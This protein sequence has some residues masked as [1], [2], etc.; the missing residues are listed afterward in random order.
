MFNKTRLSMLSLTVIAVLVFSAI[1]PK[2]VYA[3][4]DTPTN[5]STEIAGTSGSDT[6]GCDS[7]EA[8]PDSGGSETDSKGCTST[9]APTDTT[10]AGDSSGGET[11]SSECVSVEGATDTTST[12]TTN[13]DGA[14]TACTSEGAVTESTGDGSVSE[15]ENTA[16]Q[17]DQ[18]SAPVLTETAPPSDSNLLSEVPDNTSVTVL[19][20]DGQPEPLATQAAADAI[21]TT[22]DPIWCPQGQPPIPGANGCTAS[23]NSF[24]ALLTFL[25]GNAAYQGAGTIY[26]QQGAYHGGEA[27]ID[28]NSSSY[29]LSNI[30]NSDLTVQGGWD[31]TN[32]TLPPTSSSTLNISMIIGTSA[33]PWGG[34]L[35][36][37][38]LSFDKP[39]QT[40]LT[41]YSQNDITLENVNV[42]SSINGSGAE[43]NA[44]DDVTIINS[45]FIRNKNAGANITAGGNVAV[46]DSEFSNTATTRRQITGL[47]IDTKTKHTIPGKGNV[48]LFNVIANG[49]L[50]AGVNIDA[51]GRVSISNGIFSGTK[52]MTTSGGTTTFSGYGLQ[53]VTSDAIDLDN[54][55][56]NDN[57]LWGA[58]LKAGADVSG[59]GVNITNSIFNGNS[60]FSP[61][62]ID[63]TGLLI[64]SIGSVSLNNVQA[65]DNRLIG[66]VIDAVGDV[67]VNNSTF[68]NNKG[69]TLSSGGIPTFYGYGLQV[70]SQGNISVQAV[71]ASNNT[72][73]G[74]HLEAGADVNILDS[75]FN[76]QTSGSTTDQTGRGLEVISG[77]N[78]FLTNV[79]MDNNQLF[80]ANV[81]AGSDV[82]LDG[83]VATHNGQDGLQVEASCAHLTGGVFTD[84]G[85][86]GLNLNNTSLDLISAPTFANNTLGDMFPA[87]PASCSIVVASNP[88]NNSGGSS[89]PTAPTPVVSQPTTA[90]NNNGAPSTVSKQVVPQQN[91]ALNRFF[92]ATALSSANVSLNN[93]LTDTQVADGRVTMQISVFWGKYIYVY[94]TFADRSAPTD[95]IQIISLKPVLTHVA[96]VGF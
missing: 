30:R 11:V 43:L 6:S 4:D 77:G 16:P 35:T 52:S 83:V 63:D 58:S 82:F 54:V 90:G 75:N 48:S 31:T 81:K 68:S 18:T 22:S 70:V 94:S 15:A 60:T 41:L 32:N 24:N 28:L 95:G 36:I 80:G 44:D 5:V 3:D 61:I 84:N 46:S 57:F 89:N 72:L 40:G 1:S 51:A 27:S 37:N 23:F 76:L 2:I 92:F 38:N 79:V 62:F 65:N 47:Q 53:V 50:Q 7:A 19:N 12:D 42:T 34:S 78:T 91:A 69:V 39:N 71:T 87:I 33:N 17:P 9:D 88:G 45:K 93:I 49:N 85:Q 13:S 86:Y 21:T 59:A 56:A 14:S 73:F 66:A 55:T 96:M 74:A 8:A 26:V 20:T 64:T 10:G 29:D 25:S 67:S